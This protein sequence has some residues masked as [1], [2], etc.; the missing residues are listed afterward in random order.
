MVMHFL[1]SF[2]KD[3][4]LRATFGFVLQ[5]EQGMMSDGQ[6]ES[7]KLRNLSNEMHW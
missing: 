1:V 6:N 3:P 2:L 7:L 4:S 5:K